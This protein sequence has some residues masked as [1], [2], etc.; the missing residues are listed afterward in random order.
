MS[1]RIPDVLTWYL[2]ILAIVQYPMTTKLLKEQTILTTNNFFTYS[3]FHKLGIE[4]NYLKC[5]SWLQI[6]FSHYSQCSKLL[7]EQKYVVKLCTLFQILTHIS[8]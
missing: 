4:W 6:L 7:E 3:L 8:L 5:Q 2:D 1:P